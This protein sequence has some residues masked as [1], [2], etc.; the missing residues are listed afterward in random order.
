MS[1]EELPAGWSSLTLAEL[2]LPNTAKID[3]AASP[4]VAFDLWSVPNFPHGPEVLNG[5]SIGST[6]Q[7]VRDGDV[8]VCKINPRINRVEVVR[9]ISSNPQVASTEWIVVRSPACSPDY[10]RHAFTGPVFRERIGRT[11]AGVGGSLT[12][13]RP[14]EVAD[15][16]IPVAPLAEQR[17]IV[18]KLDEL[19]ARSQKAR[20]ALD[21]VPALLK[22]LKQSV[23]A[24]AFRGDLT[25]EWRA[26]QAPG[27]V[28]PAS[29]LLERIRAERRARWEQ[30]NPKK[31]YEAPEPVDTDGLPELP[32]GWCW[33]SIRELSDLITKG[34][35]PTSVGLSFTD[36][37]VRF[38]KVESL[39][40]GRIAHGQC[41]YIDIGA[42][43]VLR[44]SRLEANDVLVSI[45]G[46]LGRVAVVHPVD[47][48][49]NTNQAVAIARLVDPT[50][51]RWVSRAIVHRVK[52][53]ALRDQARGAALQNLNLQQIGELA[54][55]I[56]ACGEGELILV[57]VERAFA[58][59]ATLATD[60][61]ILLSDA[62]SL[63]QAILAKAFRGEL[64]PQ[65][66]TDE[67]AEQLLARI[68]AEAAAPQAK[69]PGPGRP[70][71]GG[72]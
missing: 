52:S 24:A 69:R 34:T 16:D 35:T 1:G 2:G 13:A 22:K 51:A 10:L 56:P 65:D 14:G 5:A 53:G 31:K 15:I 19:R 38:V 25:A 7:E 23:L 37:G 47:L 44:R 41:A 17:R 49:A 42:D 33:A 30:A 71:R 3:P 6:K 54:I 46:T 20:A 50:L 27:S 58:A 70:R 62:T 66:P 8:L 12:R 26:A 9:P 39:S 32:D 29:V 64:V 18:A 21:E 67:P 59:L 40:D 48:P 43:A 57:A 61:E 28:E 63:D 72:A 11:V 4:N 55:P 45:A 36:S 68:Q 60:A